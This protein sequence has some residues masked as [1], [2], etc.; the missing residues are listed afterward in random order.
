M[1]CVGAVF[2]KMQGTSSNARAWSAAV[3]SAKCAEAQAH[4][5]CLS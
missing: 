1:V 3:I 5:C 4:F 2:L